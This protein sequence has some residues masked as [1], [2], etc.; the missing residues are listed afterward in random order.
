MTANTKL[1]LTHEQETLLITLYAKAQAGNPLFFDPM[2][3]DILKRVDYDFARLHVPFMT[4]FLVSQ[5]AKNLDAV[6]RGFSATY[7]NGVV[8]QL[9]R[10]SDNRSWRVDNGSVTWYDLDIPPVVELSR[11]FFSESER[12]HLIAASVTDQEWLASIV[13]GGQQEKEDYNV[14]K[15]Y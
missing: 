2:T 12:Y 4:I 9:G 1:T 7:S 15:T 5:R 10:G 6:A 8:L 11:Q 14:T 3:Q 13:A